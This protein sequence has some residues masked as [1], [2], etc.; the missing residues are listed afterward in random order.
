MFYF[1]NSC[2]PNCTALHINRCLLISAINPI[3]KGTRLSLDLI[4]DVDRSKRK[5]TLEIKFNRTCDCSLCG[6]GEPEEG[7]VRVRK[8]RVWSELN[9]KWMAEQEGT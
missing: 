2:R 7:D 3:P 9:R 6:D 5:Q 1:N 8:Y 4:A